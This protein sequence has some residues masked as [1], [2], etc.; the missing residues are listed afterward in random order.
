MKTPLS[1]R[2]NKWFSEQDCDPMQICQIFEN[3]PG[4]SFFIKD[5]NHRLLHI[6]KRFL[7]RLGVSSN[8]EL[9]GKT[10]FDLFP[11]RLA[12]HFRKDDR[13]VID[14]KQPMLNIL[15]L[16]F[17]SQGLPDWYLTNKY[18]LLNGDGNVVG[19]I[20]TVRPYGE[21]NPVHNQD[22]KWERDDEIG[23]AV[24][25]IRGNFRY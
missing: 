3:I 25:Y 6:N 13:T 9:Y 14:T 23:R 7:P 8:D 22:L 2:L 12:E 4:I 5:T 20:G 10:D 19:V 17:N 16:V 1:P 18:P 11:P 24:S 21:E 15:E